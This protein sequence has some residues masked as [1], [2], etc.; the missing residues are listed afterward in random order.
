MSDEFMERMRLRIDRSIQDLEKNIRTEFKGDPIVDRES[1][2]IAYIVGSLQKRHGNLIDIGIKES[3]R[4]SNRHQFFSENKF[5]VS[6]EVVGVVKSWLGFQ[7]KMSSQTRDANF[8]QAGMKAFQTTMSYG[9]AETAETIQVDGI[10]DHSDLLIIRGY[11][12]KRANS[13][14]DAGKVKQIMFNLLCVQVLLKSY[15]EKKLDLNPNKA[16]SRIIFYY[17]NRT[18]PSP[19]SL[20][21][22]ELN[23]HFGYSISDQIEWVNS[24]FREQACALLAK[25]RG[26]T[27]G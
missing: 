26:L 10:V 27:N 7:K 9:D 14:N 11:E 25:H 23:D 1:A 13:W 12:I 19:W 8:M 5:E 16:E 22:K 20:V 4:E 15:A 17:G 2:L 21:Q 3:L 18:I 6:R 24:Y